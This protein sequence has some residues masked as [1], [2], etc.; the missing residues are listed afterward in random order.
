MKGEASSCSSRAPTATGEVV[1]RH[2]TVL[3][4]NP[5]AQTKLS[6]DVSYSG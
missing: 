5:P 2:G 3:G 6:R 1:L 4:F